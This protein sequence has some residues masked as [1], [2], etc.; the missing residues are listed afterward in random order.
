MDT[1]R[2]PVSTK[3]RRDRGGWQAEGPSLRP[4]GPIRLVPRPV[5]L[6]S[7]QTI[8][9]PSASTLLSSSLDERSPGARR[10]SQATDPPQ[11]RREQ[12]PGHRH[13]GQLER[14]GLRLPLAVG[15]ADRTVP[16]ISEESQNDPGKAR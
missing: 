9:T 11:D 16:E 4:D 1:G 6:T 15:R 2:I 5:A 14:D 3:K 7:W 13:L 12:Q 10:H 8:T